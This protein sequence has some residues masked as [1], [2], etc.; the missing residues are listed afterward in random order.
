MSSR[1]GVIVPLYQYPVD[2]STW[3]PLLEQSVHPPIDHITIRD[4]PES[5]ETSGGTLPRI[6]SHTHLHF[7]IIVNP[8]SGPGLDQAG[9]L[10]DSSYDK[11]LSL[12]NV[13]SNVQMV[14]YVR[15]DYCRRDFSD[16]ETDVRKY[17]NWSSVGSTA[18]AE[19]SLQRRFG[20]DGVFFDET[21]NLFDEAAA[22]YLARV[23]ALVKTS[24]GILSNRL[25]R[26]VERQVRL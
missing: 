12:L 19:Q 2:Q 16:V 7:I 25:V 24:Q 23:G 21:P 17:A 1:A 22:N 6:L 3:T 11:A 13:C 26:M 14:G 10:P 9:W 15:L 20:V 8:N 4:M 18:F 5:T